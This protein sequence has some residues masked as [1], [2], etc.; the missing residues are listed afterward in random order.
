MY[1]TPTSNFICA[2]GVLNINNGYT[3]FD[4][5]GSAF[6]QVFIMITLEGWTDIQISIAQAFS[7]F[8]YPY[9]IVII[10]IGAFFLLNLL[11]AIIK[12]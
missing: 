11:L 12:G 6:L 5:F 10:F 7:I 3:N 9:F 8:T 4:S 1:D 2:K